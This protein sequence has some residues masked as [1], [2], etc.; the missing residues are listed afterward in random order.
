VLLQWSMKHRRAKNHKRWLISARRGKPSLLK[1]L[2]LHRL[3]R[4]SDWQ[5]QSFLL[6][7]HLHHPLLGWW[8]LQFP[9]PLETLTT[10]HRHPLNDSPSQTVPTLP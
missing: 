9:I 8:P 7:W 1:M 2:L 6:L 10:Q 5:R 4:R 3:L